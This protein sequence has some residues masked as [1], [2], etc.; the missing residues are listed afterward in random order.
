[1]TA[2]CHRTS[3]WGVLFEAVFRHPSQIVWTGVGACAIPLWATWPVL[4]HHAAQM[5][6]FQTLVIAFA[7]AA[8]V[9]YCFEPHGRRSDQC[10]MRDDLL[11]AA[12]CALGLLGANALFIVSIRYIPPAQANVLS[13]LW[14]V[15]VVVIGAVLRLFEF[16]MLHGI[17]LL[18]GLAG[19][20]I[21]WSG[22]SLVLSP[23]GIALAV[24]SGLSW[25]VFTVFRVWQ[26]RSAAPVL[27]RGCALSAVCSLGLHLVF[28]DF[29]LPD[30]VALAAA[31]AVGV[32]PL[33][34]AN[35]CWDTGVR[36]GDSRLLATMAYGTPIAGLLLLALLGLATLTTSLMLGAVLVVL[37]GLVAGRA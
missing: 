19:V 21:I 37:A 8:A 25:A 36:C 10:A 16:R 15:M 32:L 1:M 31:V 24:L 13:Y 14:P 12:V 23:V 7:V 18:I 4:A 29:V 33:A 34:L 5:P 30:R 2:D 28:E 22:S 27:A 9:L 17:S 26:G 20:S 35:L 3:R 11:P 6:V